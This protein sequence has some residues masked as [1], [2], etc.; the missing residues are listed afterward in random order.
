METTGLY[1]IGS[2]TERV[3]QAQFLDEMNCIW[4]L[5]ALKIVI[6]I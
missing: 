1:G 6:I 3:W 5:H 2:M 4:Y